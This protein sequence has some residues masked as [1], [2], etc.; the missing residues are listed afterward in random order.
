V[1]KILIA[2]SAMF[3]LL[4]FNL[5]LAADFNAAETYTTSCHGCHGLD[6]SISASGIESFKGKSAADL[7]KMLVGYQDGTYGGQGKMVMTGLVKPFSAEELKALG[8]YMA[9]M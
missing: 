3:C 1:N 4:S 9:K 5:A 2:F 6:G 7:E 8:E